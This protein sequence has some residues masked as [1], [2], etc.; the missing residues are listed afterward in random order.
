MVYSSKTLITRRRFL[1]T[2]TAVA[3]GVGLLPAKATQ[4]S[5]LSILDQAITLNNNAELIRKFSLPATWNSIRLGLLLTYTGITDDIP[6]SQFAIG[7]C[8]DS[9]AGYSAATPEHFVGV[10]FVNNYLKQD[11][12]LDQVFLGAGPWFVM[13][14]GNW[15]STTKGPGK[16]VDGTVTNGTHVA[17]SET[18]AYLINTYSVT[19]RRA[20]F[21]DFI[22]GSPWTIKGYFYDDGTD[23]APTDMSPNGFN[24]TPPVNAS[25]NGYFTHTIAVDEA[26]DGALNCVNLYWKAAWASLNVHHIEL[27][28]MS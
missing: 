11:G 16:I 15:S 20:L 2:G 26:T 8:H 28:R 27:W 14:I 13:Q 6:N 10:N 9:T 25:W 18:N 5:I 23:I 7:L 3:L 17:S 12:T 24:Q 1:V 22:K 4:S 19:R 21:L